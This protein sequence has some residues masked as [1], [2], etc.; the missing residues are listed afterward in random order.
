MSARRDPDCK[1]META[2]CRACNETKEV[3][4]FPPSEAKKRRPR[5]RACAR[6][7]QN[8]WR[9]QN[10]DKVRAYRHAWY[11]RNRASADASAA[12][13]EKRNRE[14]RTQRQRDH[15]ATGWKVNYD[16]MSRYGIS[17]DGY[18]QMLEQQGGQCAICKTDG[19]A[20]SRRLYVDH[21]HQTG[22][23]R[24][25]LCQKC[26][27]GL[28]FFRDDSR[29]VAQAL[30]Y[31]Q[32]SGDGSG[33]TLRELAADAVMGVGITTGWFNRLKGGGPH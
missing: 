31:L 20:G 18:Q 23:V 14:K 21:C 30:A 28:G 26:N 19:L 5:C 15:R 32:G 8:E 6:A 16:L 12:A 27:S 13:W 24:G 11:E 1:W 33:V 3:E 22:V 9:A 10:P 4:S 2:V 17:A 29:L 7:K 25:L